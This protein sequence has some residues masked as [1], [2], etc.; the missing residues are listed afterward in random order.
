MGG[1][2]CNTALSSDSVGNSIKSIRGLLF[3][4]CIPGNQYGRRGLKLLEAIVYENRSRFRRCQI[5]VKWE[6]LNNPWQCNS[7]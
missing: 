1:M 4:N 5:Y 2:A 3:S 7:L 6:E